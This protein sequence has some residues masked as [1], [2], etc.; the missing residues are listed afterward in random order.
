MYYSSKK[1]PLSLMS[2]PPINPQNRTTPAPETTPATVPTSGGVGNTPTTLSSASQPQPQSEGY[3]V[4][5]LNWVCG[6]ISW[7]FRKIFCCGSPAVQ[8]QA[9][10]LAAPPNTP[11]VPV[12]AVP[13]EPIQRE[14]RVRRAF[15]NLP[16]LERVLIYENIGRSRA[17]AWSVRSYAEIGRRAAAEDYRL[18]EQAMHLN[19]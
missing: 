7:I 2:T 3:I 18:L 5:F 1:Y 13:I 15:E 14:A 10:P 12:V 16:E 6:W 8:N 4:P 11:P 17:R 9:A 19:N